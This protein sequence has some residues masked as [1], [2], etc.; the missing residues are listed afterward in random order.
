MGVIPRDVVEQVRDQ[1]DMVE[2]IG[3][4]VTLRRRGNSWVGLCPFHQEKTPSFNVVAHKNLYH[5]HGCQASGD[6]FSFLMNIEGLSFPEAVREAANAAG[7]TIETREQSPEERRRQRQRASLYEILE[8]ATSFFEAQLWTTDT[9]GA[10][11]EYL[12]S[13]D[14]TP[15]VCCNFQL[16]WAP[17]GWSTLT[18]RFIRD[19]YTAQQLLAAGLVSPR[20]SGSGVV[21]FFRER[22][23][24]PIRDHRG[25]VISFGGRVLPGA[26]GAKYMNGRD[27]D[28]YRKSTTLY[29]LDSASPHL[30]RVDRVLLVEG[31][32]DV[33]ALQ[34]NGFPE[35]VATCGTSLTE[36]HIRR[37]RTRVRDVVVLT[38]ADRAGSDAAEKMLPMFVG[39]R[40]Q[41]WRIQLPD[42]KD[43]D[44]LVRNEGPEAMHKA[45]KTRKPL[46]D[47]V[48]ERKRARHGFDSAGRER[49]LN[50]ILDLLGEVSPA[51]VSAAASILGLREE[52]V[53]ERI[54]K[55]PREAQR[56]PHLE[57][58]PPDLEAEQYPPWRPTS[59]M[60]HLLWLI[61]HRY[62]HVADLLERFE[63][64]HLLEAHGPAL[65]ALARLI[66]GEPCAS[67][68]ADETHPMVR[69]TLAAVISRDELYAVDA[70]PRALVDVL[71]RFSAPLRKRERQRVTQALDVAS[72]Q[73]D[74]EAVRELLAQRK[75]LRAGEEAIA[76]GFRSVGR[77][78]ERLN[79]N[80]PKDDRTK[81]SADIHR[82]LQHIVSR[83]TDFADELP[84][85]P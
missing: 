1:V 71:E 38:D 43:P 83:L 5:C 80:N 55:R 56:S 2:I 39:A 23:I 32:F 66:Q 35:A 58:P 59:D 4:R 49:T 61:V 81:I 25:R 26:E 12:A 63:G 3:K 64:R 22:V 68:V 19:G 79:R 16:G 11:R 54:R 30:A 52:L 44:E 60:T 78:Q 70:S 34:A 8:Q 41:A 33:I 62:D 84:V 75:A 14:L 37:L 10:A 6:V 36:D 17:S 24:I 69:R 57:G 13:R 51:Q 7:I 45:L 82:E 27:T 48:V 46:F 15:E 47:W 77:L 31:Y 28:V 72:R 74:D 20:R 73:E 18:D 50:E 67:V 29:G 76:N 65:P 85:S 40:M 9:G 42:A 53:I 21:D